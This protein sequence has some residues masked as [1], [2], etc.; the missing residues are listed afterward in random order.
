MDSIW[1]SR[2]RCGQ[3]RY[4][5][6]SLSG[7]IHIVTN[8]GFMTIISIYQRSERFCKITRRTSLYQNQELIRFY[9]ISIFCGAS[10]TLLFL[11]NFLSS[12]YIYYSQRRIYTCVMYMLS[13][14]L[15]IQI[16]QRCHRR[17]LFN[18]SYVL[19]FARN[20][21][22]MLTRPLCITMKNNKMSILYQVM[23]L[24]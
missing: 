20:M 16:S 8:V 23:I 22:I 15:W 13:K 6:H 7:F 18:K 1:S 2:F 4:D 19:C 17:A 9:L 3:S 10:N 24:F 14:R 21:R 5:S 12:L 11:T